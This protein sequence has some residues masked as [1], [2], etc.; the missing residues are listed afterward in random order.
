MTNLAAWLFA[1]VQPLVSR[2]LVVLGLSFATYQGLDVVLNTLVTAV[3]T[4]WAALPATTIQLARLAGIAE[5][6]SIIGSAVA[7]RLLIV[8]LQSSKAFL[9]KNQST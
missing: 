1:L 5:G 4:S 9:T 3:S 7:T 2:V 6:L 8:S